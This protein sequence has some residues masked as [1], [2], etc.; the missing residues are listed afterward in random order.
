MDAA[1]QRVVSNIY[2][3]THHP[4]LA[5]DRFKIDSNTYRMCLAT[6]GEPH[7]LIPGYVGLYKYGGNDT[8]WGYHAIVES[9]STETLTVEYGY[10]EPTIDDGSGVVDLELLE[11]DD[12][13]NVDTD[14]A[15]E[16]FTTSERFTLPETG[17]FTW[18]PWVHTSSRSTYQDNFDTLKYVL[19]FYDTTGTFITRLDSLI[20]CDSVP[21]V[22]GETRSITITQDNA[23]EGYVTFRRLTEGLVSSTARWEPIVMTERLSD[24]GAYK[25]VGR[26]YQTTGNGLYIEA[27]P[28]PTSGETDISFIIPNDGAVTIEA[29]NSLGSSAALILQGSHMKKGRHVVRWDTRK[30]PVGVYPLMLLFGNY[31]ETIRVIVIR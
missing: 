22:L 24:N 18:Y 28:N 6:D 13:L 4:Q 8:L 10:G 3:N 2:T 9:D 12:T 5:V 30:L 14:H 20:L 15:P 11:M 19:D 26:N 17:T 23:V 1:N 27:V 31:T 29:Y 21:N 7:W 25:R 16:Y